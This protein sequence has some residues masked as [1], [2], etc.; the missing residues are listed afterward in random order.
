MKRIIYLLLLPFFLF[1]AVDLTVTNLHMTSLSDSRPNPSFAWDANPNAAGYQISSDGGLHW[2]DVGNVTTYTFAG[3]VPGNY[4][5]VIRAYALAA[6][7]PLFGLPG[8]AALALLFG[9]GGFG[10]L[11]RQKQRGRTVLF[12]PFSLWQ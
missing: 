7:V 10:L 5:V 3:L 6:E 8:F 2:I 12:L 11:R 1:A 9:L 4:S